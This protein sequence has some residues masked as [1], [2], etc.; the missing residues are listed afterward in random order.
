MMTATD[1]ELV[2]QEVGRLSGVPEK[3]VS[4]AE[5]FLGSD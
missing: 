2:Q 4:E 3:D 5:D 1:Y